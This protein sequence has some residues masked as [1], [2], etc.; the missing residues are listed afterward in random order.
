[1]GGTQDGVKVLRSCIRSFD[2]PPS[3]S[4][5]YTLMPKPQSAHLI[6]FGNWPSSPPVFPS[7]F[8]A[9]NL[10]TLLWLPFYTSVALLLAIVHSLL[11]TS[12][13][14]PSVVS[15]APVSLKVL[16]LLTD[17]CTLVSVHLPV[18]WTRLRWP[19][20]SL[21]GPFGVALRNH[22]TTSTPDSFGLLLFLV[23]HSPLKRSS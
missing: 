2:V 18:P 11:L 17:K 19:T 20:P 23:R 1:M 7:P 15:E 14:R 12:P 10:R 5:L 21:S 13:L 3:G 4:P 6:N 22:L 16:I 8:L 9:F